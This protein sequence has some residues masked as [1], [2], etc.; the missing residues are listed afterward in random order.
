MKTRNV[1]STLVVMIASAVFAFAGA[2]S[3]LVVMNASKA[4]VFKVIYEGPTSAKVVMKITNSNGKVLFSETMN[5]LSKF[6]RPLNFEG[7]EPGV[8]N[9]EITDENGT[10]IQKINYKVSEE[11]LNANEFKAQANVSRLENGKYLLSVAGKGT[12]N[13]DVTILDGNDNVIYHDTLTVNEYRALVYNV[14]QVEGQPVFQ[15]TDAAGNR[16]K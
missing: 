6:S 4:E 13:V 9:V 16:I 12:G 3:K 8:Y 2:P 11:A 1:L 10:Q 14:M 5:G 7:M 15:V